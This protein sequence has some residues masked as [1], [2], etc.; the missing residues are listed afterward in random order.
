[1]IAA[2]RIL[3]KLQPGDLA[4][5]RTAWSEAIEPLL[6]EPLTILGKHAGEKFSVRIHGRIRFNTAPPLKATNEARTIS[7]VD[8]AARVAG[9]Y[10]QRLDVEASS[11]SGFSSRTT[12]PTG[13]RWHS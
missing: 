11:A 2:A 13:A 6:G 8:A 10:W 1:V 3:A 4:I 12:R 7:Q 9:C 5:E